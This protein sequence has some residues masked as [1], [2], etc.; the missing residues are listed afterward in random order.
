MPWD[1]EQEP[2]AA[3]GH[4]GP[5]SLLLCARTDL[6]RSSPHAPA[7]IP[8]ALWLRGS[9]PTQA[10][11]PGRSIG[12][13]DGGLRWLG[14]LSPF[15]GPDPRALAEPV[16]TRCFAVPSA[17]RGLPGCALPVVSGH[18]VA[19]RESSLSD[20]GS[21]AAASE[22]SSLTF[23][24]RTAMPP[25]TQEACTGECQIF[26]EAVKGV[27]PSGRCRDARR[28]SPGPTPA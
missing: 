28:R 16:R 23:W 9:R 19:R 2:E 8:F 21:F 6:C 27:E 10:D 24:L 20:R 14:C 5:P 7:R 4:P 17:P 22:F 13:E 26:L 18:P 15:P 12:P 11:G 25:I 3:E 1:S